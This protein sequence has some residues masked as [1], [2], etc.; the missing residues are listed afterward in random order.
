MYELLIL[1]IRIHETTLDDISSVGR[2]E[3]RPV[4]WGF[5]GAQVFVGGVALA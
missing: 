1:K 4:V 3:R 5:G 2:I